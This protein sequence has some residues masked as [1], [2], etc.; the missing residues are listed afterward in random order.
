MAIL[1]DF[2]LF[3]YSECQSKVFAGFC[4]TIQVK[5]SWQFA[6][7]QFT[8][9]QIAFHLRCKEFICWFYLL[10]FHLP[11]LCLSFKQYFIH[12]SWEI[13]IFSTASCHSTAHRLHFFFA[14][15]QIYWRIFFIRWK[16]F[17][18][19][20]CWSSVEFM[21]GWL[22]SVVKIYVWDSFVKCE[23]KIGYDI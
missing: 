6:S 19:C 14:S 20:C 21:R 8:S 22:S 4:A 10:V 11:S 18:C 1:W 3:K 9:V 23:L 12:L 2:D 16:L 15:F 7:F 5:S 13:G 17:F